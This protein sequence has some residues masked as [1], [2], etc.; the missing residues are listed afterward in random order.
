MS[1]R[2]AM[3][4]A[5]IAVA[6][7]LARSTISTT[8]ADLREARIVVERAPSSQ[9]RVVGRPVSVFA[10][11]PRAGTCVGLHLG[12]RELRLMVADVAHT[13]LHKA[14]VELGLDY[15]P[16][17]AVRAARQAIRDAYRRCGLPLRSLLGVGI[18]V[19]G[20]VA[21]DGSVQRASVVP[22]WAGVDVRQA[23][24]P[25]L[26]KPI[27]ADNES[28]CG[29]LA[30]MT[31]GA[32]TDLADFVYFKIDMGLGGAIVVRRRVVTGVAGAG[33][34]FGHISIDPRGGLCRC[35]NR[36]CLELTGSFRPVVELLSRRLRRSVTID[37]VVERATSGDAECRDAISGIGEVA[38]RGLGII[39]S[40][41]N[42]GV[43]VI[44][45]RGLAAGPLL[46]E[47]LEA[48]YERHTLLK[49]AQLSEAHRVRI[50]PAHFAEDGSLMGAVAL[51]LRRYGGLQDRA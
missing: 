3:S 31:W 27:F 37:D 5:E 35:G 14:E 38:G 15:A 45:G 42:P 21:A 22:T 13:V 41:L 26:Q 48:S 9:A 30:E 33:G 16:P 11:N 7:G 39:G 8:L 50:M 12:L 46:L 47:P 43:V 51:V 25:A 6:T 20:P 29:A 19:A 10:L 24:E 36:G 1:E 2:G 49:R 40:I 32:A 18:A 28:N 17:S 34:E 4:P 23:F 44:G